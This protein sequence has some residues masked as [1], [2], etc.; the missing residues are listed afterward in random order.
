[1][2]LLL[3]KRMFLSNFFFFLL[4]LAPDRKFA[5]ENRR[6][7]GF[8]RSLAFKKERLDEDEVELSNNSQSIN[9]PLI[10]GAS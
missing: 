1:M 8:C 7:G 4:Y 6:F 10:R 9:Y 2:L 5:F 3:Y